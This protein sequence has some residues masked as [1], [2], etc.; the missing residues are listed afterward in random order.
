MQVRTI[1]VEAQEARR[2][3]D[4]IGEVGFDFEL[5]RLPDESLLGPK[6]DDVGGLS[7]IGLIGEDL[8]ATFQDGGDFGGG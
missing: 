7:K 4:G 5:A 2:G 6:G 3:S 8:D 1:R